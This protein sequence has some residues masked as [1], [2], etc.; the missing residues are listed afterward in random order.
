MAIQDE[1]GKAVFESRAI[2]RY[3]AAKA[4]SPLLLAG[5][6]AK[7]AVPAGRVD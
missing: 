6:A 3:I 5:D 2:A 7:V 4:A 1:A